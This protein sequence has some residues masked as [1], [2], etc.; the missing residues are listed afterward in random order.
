MSSKL[1]LVVPF[2]VLLTSVIAAA[3]VSSSLSTQFWS[4]E[5]TNLHPVNQEIFRDLE[6]SDDQCTEPVQ[7]CAYFKMPNLTDE[8]KQLVKSLYKEG[9]RIVHSESH[10]IFLTECLNLKIIPK[11]FKVQTVIPGNRKNK[12]G[13]SCAKLSSSWA[14]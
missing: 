6:S 2:L 10:V 7:S 11:A 1:R 9:K 12:L 13:L 14:G 3:R 4:T 5:N 8:H